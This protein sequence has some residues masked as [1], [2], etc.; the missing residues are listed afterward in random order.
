M[1][2]PHLIYRIDRALLYSSK[3][4]VERRYIENCSADPNEILELILKKKLFYKKNSNNLL[5][6]R[7]AESIVLKKSILSICSSFRLQNEL[8]SRAATKYDPT[9]KS[10][11]KKLLEFWDLIKPN[12]ALRSKISEQWI[13]IGF[14]GSD[15]STDF[16]GMG[17]L[18]LDDLHYFAK[19]YPL[20]CQK[21][22]KTSVH[23]TAWFS[24][25]I[26]GINITSYALN[27]VR[28]RS[29]QLYLYT[30][31]C[32]KEVYHEFYCYMFFKFEEEWTKSFYK[33]PGLTCMDFNNVFKEFQ[34][35]IEKELMSFSPCRIQSISLVDPVVKKKN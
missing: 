30:N 21:V 32:E 25:A 14:Q 13:S 33:S 5:E 24:M 18:G 17:M 7:K 15:P 23:P 16:R 3:L 4:L 34:S 1:L 10:H 26:V 22:L 19:N 12:E 20:E 11:E 27:L 31:G 6:L 35:R 2:S 9:N 29:L 28:T 8:N